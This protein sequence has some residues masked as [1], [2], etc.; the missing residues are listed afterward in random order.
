[1]MPWCI[2][3]HGA[4]CRSGGYGARVEL[5]RRG[6]TLV[7]LLVVIAIIA[8]LIGLLLPAVQSA[9]EA[10][11]RSSCISNLKQIGLSNQNFHDSKRSLP[12]AMRCPFSKTNPGPT[13]PDVT[14]QNINFQL[15]A[16]MEETAVYDAGSAAWAG[17]PATGAWS[18]DA[19]FAG[20][21]SNIV[22]AKV[23]KGFICPSD[24]TVSNGYPSNQVN[25]WSACNYAA[26]FMLF[27]Q[28]RTTTYIGGSGMPDTD[29]GGDMR[30]AS[31]G[32]SKTVA[33]AERIANCQTRDGT[34]ISNGGSLLFWPGGNW[35]WSAHDWGPTFANGGVGGQGNNWNQVPMTRVTNPNLCDRSRPSTAHEVCLVVM[36]DGATKAVSGAVDQVIWQNAFTPSDGLVDS[37]L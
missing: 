32:T 12:G 10:A 6:F 20:A 9:R 21:P 4:G 5:R 26:N 16:Y 34:T 29:S 27:G 28:K 22:R 31:D 33:Y 8:V 13:P 30:L 25:A 15:M 1:M 24:A 14:G 35:W 17:M 11:R 2:E 18:W 7:E 19:P 23:V 37:G 36:L 3:V